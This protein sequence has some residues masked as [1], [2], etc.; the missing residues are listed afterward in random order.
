MGQK[1]PWPFP[2]MW[3]S[4]DAEPSVGHA[5]PVPGG[6][7]MRKSPQTDEYWLRFRRAFPAAPA[8]Y[9][10]LWF[11][12][13]DVAL[14]TKLAILVERGPKRATTALLRDFETGIE[15]VFPKPGDLW[16]VVD[17]DGMPR[18]VVRTT[19]VDITAFGKV[20]GQFAWDE[21][22]GDRTLADWREG[23]MRYFTRQA[24]AQ[25][26]EFGDATQVVLERFTVIWPPDVAD[27]L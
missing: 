1:L 23:H 26:F 16:L 27:P 18:C 5:A 12:D 8:D 2:R 15:P 13:A 4:L 21:G 17:G 22:E 24:M 20:D 3:C 11:G 10:L 7:F 9:R 14:A 25:G 19:H 6:S